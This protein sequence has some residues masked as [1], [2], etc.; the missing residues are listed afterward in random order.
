MTDKVTQSEVKTCQCGSQLIPGFYPDHCFSEPDEAG[1]QYVTGVIPAWV[2]P[3]CGEHTLL[4][5]ED[6]TSWLFTGIRFLGNAVGAF[7][8]T[9]KLAQICPRFQ[10]FL[11]EQ[12]PGRDIACNGCGECGLDDTEDEECPDGRNIH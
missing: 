6:M 8:I 9:D 10:E 3:A 1:E 2:C 4:K 7:N 12:Y 11:R 5:K